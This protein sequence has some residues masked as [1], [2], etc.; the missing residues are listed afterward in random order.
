[1]ETCVKITNLTDYTDISLLGYV[2]GP[3]SIPT[4]LITSS[5]CLVKGYKYNTLNIFAVK[6]SYLSDKDITTIDWLK[7][8]SVI[9]SNIPIESFGEYLSNSIPISA[10]NQFYRIVGFTETSVVLYKYM[11]V[12]K[13]N[14]GKSDSVITYTYAG[15][16]TLLSQKLIVAIPSSKNNSTVELYPNPVKK[17]FYIKLSSTYQGIISIKIL[18]SDGKVVSILNTNKTEALLNYSIPLENLSKGTYFVT[19]TMGTAVETK[20]IFID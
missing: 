10:I 18:S 6:N 19:I 2:T 11:E 13:F 5:E 16:S 7:D 4:Y 3:K 15:D 8:N 1:V 14:N 12:N 17:S 20:K 9:K